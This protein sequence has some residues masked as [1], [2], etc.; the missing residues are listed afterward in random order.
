MYNLNSQSH[1]NQSY[2][3]MKTFQ[4][5][6]THK[7]ANKPSSTLDLRINC[8]MI[9]YAYYPSLYIKTNNNQT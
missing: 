2:S 7:Y 9:L 5:L 4:L 1:T 8:F 3:Q 6:N